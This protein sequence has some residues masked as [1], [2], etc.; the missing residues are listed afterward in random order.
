[1]KG[2]HCFIVLPLMSHSSET[3]TD[4]ELAGRKHGIGKTTKVSLSVSC[5]LFRSYFKIHSDVR[6]GERF[7]FLWN[8]NDY[9]CCV[10]STPFNILCFEGAVRISMSAVTSSRCKH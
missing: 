10:I 9:R 3:I 4:H 1:M 2:G 5:E 6:T 7:D 8:W